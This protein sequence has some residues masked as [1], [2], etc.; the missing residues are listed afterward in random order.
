[1][2][3]AEGVR[4][5]EARGPPALQPGTAKSNCLRIL[6]AG[7]TPRE[8]VLLFGDWWFW[9]GWSGADGARMASIRGSVPECRMV[10]DPDEQAN[11]ADLDQPQPVISPP[12][13]EAS[14][15]QGPIWRHISERISDHLVHRRFVDIVW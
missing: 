12:Q 4:A 11:V 15:V 2:S 7:Y 8:Y 3:T 13:S 14:V 10:P 6:E 9:P 1:M 5:E